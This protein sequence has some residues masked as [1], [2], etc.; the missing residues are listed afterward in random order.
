MAPFQYAFTT[1]SDAECIAHA[2]QT[3]TDLDDRATVRSI[4]GTGVF[5]L[6]SRGAVLEGFAILGR[7]QFSTPMCLAVPREPFV[8]F[9]D[10]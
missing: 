1:K 5:D 6:V 3:L 2:L 7:R 4:D 10:R 8:T 9:V